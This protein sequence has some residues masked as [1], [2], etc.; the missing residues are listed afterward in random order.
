MSLEP[1]TNTVNK[2]F[3]P[4]DFHYDVKIRKK[5]LSTLNQETLKIIEEATDKTVCLFFCKLSQEVFDKLVDKCKILAFVDTF[6]T[7]NLKMVKQYEQ[8]NKVI[9]FLTHLTYE[10]YGEYSHRIKMIVENAKRERII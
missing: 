10:Q 6:S 5:D 4:P 2:P 9:A 1:V 3:L 7:D 8:N